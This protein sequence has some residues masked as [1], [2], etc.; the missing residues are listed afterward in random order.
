MVCGVRRESGM[1]TT[2]ALGVLQQLR[3]QFHRTVL[4]RRKDTLFELA[5]ALLVADGPQPLVH[6]SLSPAVQHGW[7][8]L[9]DALSAGTLDAAALQRLLLP[10]LP[11]PERGHPVWVVDG[12]TWPRP[13]AVTSPERTW[14]Y[15][16]SAGIPQHGLVPGW[17][18]QWLVAVPEPGT[19]WV[20]PLDITRRGPEA[21][22]PTQV[23]VA[24]LR[25]VLPHVPPGPEPV[26]TAD[27][28][29]DL[30][31]LLTTCHPDAPDRVAVTPLLRLN[32][33]RC[34][35]APPAPYPGR[36]RRPT[37][38]PKLHLRDPASLPPPDQ[39]LI[40]ADPRHDTLTIDLWR[41]IRV[42][43]HGQ[44]PFCLVR[45]Q[46]A[47]LPQSARPPD[48][49]WLA[50]CAPTPPADLGDLWRWY[51]LRFTVEHG[52]RFSKHELG[53]T[54]VRLRAPAAAD[55]WSQLILVTWWQLWL[56]RPLVAD[57]HLPWER[58]LPPARLTP[59]RVRRALRA[60][61]PTLGSPVP[62]LQPRGKSPG[63]RPGVQPDPHPHQ[64]LVKRPARAPPKAA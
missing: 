38:G 52:F 20:V 6:Y 35:A 23:A 7:P 18:Y 36:G 48:P 59:R 11:V 13:A 3:T 8:S 58:D 37:Y 30:G 19:S 40:L 63:R 41:D 62:T 17:A 51:S 50:W 32:R 46:A 29:Y 16:P 45:L 54:T 22:T 12:T 21:A 60:I 5:D 49:L 9:P 42:R 53:W 56:A 2:D 33:R 61:L 10:Y 55:R 28:G 43:P 31:D 57:A 44:Y 26:L 47:R 64:P 4:G 27:T 34:V 15:R 14:C 24:Q 39:S 25:A 1:E